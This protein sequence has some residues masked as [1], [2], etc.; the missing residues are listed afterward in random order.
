MNIPLWIPDMARM[1]N[2]KRITLSVFLP[3]ILLAPASIHAQE[4]QDKRASGPDPS[5]NAKLWDSGSVSGRNLLLGPGGEEMKPDVSKVTF[6]KEETQGH[7]K[8]YRINDAA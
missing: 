4:K 7:N 1:K 8:K 3:A 5:T 6:I 2:L